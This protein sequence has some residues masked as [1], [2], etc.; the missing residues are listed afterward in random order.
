MPLW[1][2][3]GMCA[4][5]L[6]LWGRYGRNRSTLPYPPG[7]PADPVIGHLRTMPPN[8]TAH[9]VFH[10]WSQRY[11]DVMYLEVLRKPLLIL[12]SEEA[13]SDLLDKHGAIYS[14]RPSF[15]LAER[16]GW[17]KLLGFLSPGSEFREARKALQLFLDKNKVAD[18]KDALDK[19]SLVLLHDLLQDPKDMDHL[20]H[21]YTSTVIMDITYGHHMRSKDDGIFRMV[22]RLI[23]I[24]KE[25]TRPSL[26]DLSPIFQWL[27]SWFPGAWYQNFIKD[28][29]PILQLVMQYPVSLVQ[30]EMKLGTAR[31]SF[32]SEQLQAF[33]Q[34]SATT[35]EHV[36][37]V[38]RRAFQIMSGG[39]ETTWHSVTQ[40]FACML[41]HPD[42]QRRAQE[43]I[44]RVVG[45][46]RLPDFT[47]R[48]ALPYVE[49]VLKEVLRW[50]PIVP[51]GMPH[52]LRE[53]H[54][55]RGMFIP[56]GTTVITNTTAMCLDERK[57]HDAHLFKPERFL[58][59]PDGAGEVLPA[60]VVYGWGRRICPGRFLAD[61]AAWLAMVR[62]LA[63]FVITKAKD[64]HG[65]EMEPDIKFSVALT[66]HPLPFP[67]DI[68][69]RS[70]R[71][72]ALVK[73]VYDLAQAADVLAA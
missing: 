7:P 51:L 19:A 62:I 34:E 29:K 58:P 37:E 71:A 36:H 13:A 8:A 26:L 60:N 46:G 20:V 32:V 23:P 18:Y 27:P 35:A 54:T 28:A 9:H 53:D 59:K 15:P 70:E 50:K 33:S 17:T 52:K 43:E 49:C 4:V 16:L 61:N 6:G 42:A 63:V 12:S 25:C 41:L 64:A 45:S 1:I 21:F 22:L 48:D 38:E 14:D 2:I 57:F 56:G 55:Y 44:D 47:D 73:E 39:T 30:K 69:P 10:D 72:A 3:F 67:C 40:F 5:L 11:G 66:S 65:Q 68:R 24:F 31:P